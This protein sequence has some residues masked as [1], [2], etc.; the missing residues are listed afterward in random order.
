MEEKFM[1][2]PIGITPTLEGKDAEEFL[3]K[4]GEGPTEKDKKIDEK[5]NKQR[6]VFFN[7]IH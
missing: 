1:A 3:K 5:I 6:K 7:H 4:M 2:K